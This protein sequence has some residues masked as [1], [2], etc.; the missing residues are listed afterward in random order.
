M[1]DR[2]DEGYWSCILC[3][4]SPQ[5]EMFREQAEELIEMEKASY[6][7]RRKKNGGR[8]T[9]HRGASWIRTGGVKLG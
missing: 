6:G 9:V 8:E 4:R 2:E 1:E 3:G 5:Q 7:R